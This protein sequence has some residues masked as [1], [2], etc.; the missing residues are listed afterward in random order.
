MRATARHE[1]FVKLPDDGSN[2][3]ID[4]FFTGV[5]SSRFRLWGVLGDVD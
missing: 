4:D 1:L 5:V 2:G 3:V